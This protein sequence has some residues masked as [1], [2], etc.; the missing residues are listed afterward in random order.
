MVVVDVYMRNGIGNI[1][2]FVAFD[3]NSHTS[4]VR[5][6]ESTFTRALRIMLC[7]IACCLAHTAFCGYGYLVLG[8]FSI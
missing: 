8:Q 2:L 7:A 5:R 6:V 4:A 3:A 1:C